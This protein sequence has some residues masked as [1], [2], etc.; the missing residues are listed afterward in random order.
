MSSKKKS[1]NALRTDLILD[2]GRYEGVPA[3]TLLEAAAC[4]YIAVDQR[5]L[6]AILDQPERAVPDLVRFGAAP[7][8][9]RLWI[10]ILS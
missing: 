3:Y 4:G 9:T 6:H 8:T 2:P 7:Q 10:W 1:S 5:L